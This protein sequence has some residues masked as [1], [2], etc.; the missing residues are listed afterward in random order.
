VFRTQVKMPL[1]TVVLVSLMVIGCCVAAAEEERFGGT[2]RVAII[3]EPT[4]LDMFHAYGVNSWKIFQHIVEPLFEYDAEWQPVP[5]L[6]DSYTAED[7]N[8]RYILN[9]RKG[10]MFHNGKEMKAE[11]VQTSFYRY[12]RLNSYWK[13]VAASKLI[14]MNI[15][16]DYTVEILLNSP[17]GLIPYLLVDAWVYPKEVIDKYGDTPV[18][19]NE[20][21][22]TGPYKFS[23]WLPD[24]FIEIVRFD[25]YT[26]NPREF[27]GHAGKK[28]AYLDAIR[29]MPV[30]DVS[31]RTAGVQ[32]GDYDIA[33]ELNHDLYNRLSQERDLNTVVVAPYGAPTIFFNKAEGIMAGDDGLKVRQAFLAALNMEE[34][35]MAAFGNKQLYLVDGSVYTELQPLW[36]STAGTE[37]YNQNNIEKAKRLLQEAG[38]KGEPIRFMTSMQYDFL[39]R[40]SLVAKQQLEK[41]G[42]KIDLQVLEWATLVDRR[43]R[44]SEWDAFITYN[45]FSPAPPL[46]LGWLMSSF[47]GWWDD[48][49]KERLLAEL[50]ASSTY[51][52]QYAIWEEIQRLAYEQAAMARIGEF[53]AFNLASDKVK[54][55]QPI[56]FMPYYNVWIEE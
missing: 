16:D 5:H 47:P 3:G 56:Y 24:R 33:E 4:G 39:Y 48:E 25:G 26:P 43:A 36:Y 19:A 6:L 29:F 30:P 51:E 7:N 11:D 50:D 54:G 32:A 9:L 52:E 21:I 1:I 42:F 37:L 8:T 15:V 55:L 44:P 31:V 34:M 23:R 22:G 41:A 14:E 10:V 45:S 2:L 13:S 35:M 49:E 18:P 53:F 17:S 40:I 38:Y 12:T 27:S 20:I 46:R 28:V